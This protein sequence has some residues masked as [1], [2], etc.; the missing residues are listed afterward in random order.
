MLRTISYLIILTGDSE[1]EV[2]DR[3]EVVYSA[4]GREE[5]E[6]FQAAGLAET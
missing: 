6:I 1:V 2:D 5:F 3:D 4:Y